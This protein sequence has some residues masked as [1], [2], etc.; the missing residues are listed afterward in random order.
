MRFSRNGLHAAKNDMLSKYLL[1]QLESFTIQLPPNI[2]KSPYRKF[3]TYAG[4][5]QIPNHFLSNCIMIIPHLCKSAIRKL[6]IYA[7]D[8][9]AKMVQRL[10]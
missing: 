10:Q 6:P 8:N 2:C 7:S 1:Y 5:W 9:Q 3:C 4:N